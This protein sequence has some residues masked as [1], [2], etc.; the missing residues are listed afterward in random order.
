MPA[1]AHHFG[2]IHNAATAHGHDEIAFVVREQSHSLDALA[3]IG[4]QAHFIVDRNN[5][6]VGTAALNQTDD[7]SHVAPG[8]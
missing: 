3:D 4:I 1:Y 8:V 2:A 7:G 5:T 6:D